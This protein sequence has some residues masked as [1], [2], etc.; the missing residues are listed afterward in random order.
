M[1]FNPDEIEK[2]VME[3]MRRIYSK[4]AIDHAMNPKNVGHLK[5]PDGEAKVTGSCGD[6]MEISLRIKDGNITDAR[7]WTDGCGSSIACG[8]V[9]TELIKGKSIPEVEK[10]E[11]TTVLETL[12]GLPDSDVHCAVLASKTLKAAIENTHSTKKGQQTKRN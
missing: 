1:P 8:S 11:H 12:D 3:E 9:I 6:T 10:I 5:E 2:M 4:K 7:F